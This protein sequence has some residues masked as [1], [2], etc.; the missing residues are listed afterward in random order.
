MNPAAL[1]ELLIREGYHE[2][3]FFAGA[4]Q[5][6]LHELSE[7]GDT[8]LEIDL[9][10]PLEK[11][12]LAFVARSLAVLEA[13]VK[14]ALL[15][16]FLEPEELSHFRSLDSLLAE[17]RDVPLRV[18]ALAIGSLKV[19]VEGEANEV[20][21]FFGKQTQPRRWKKKFIAMLSAFVGGGVVA[22][23]LFGL[24]QPP[25]N[26]PE[27]SAVTEPIEQACGYL[28]AGTV[29]TIKAGVVEAEIPCQ[30]APGYRR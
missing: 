30:D 8:R 29:L 15:F 19:T 23:S 17:F 10:I 3:S 26:I 27:P 6:F 16:T 24:P 7:G 28:P 1:Q 20:A 21:N 5:E 14:L 22:L 9:A 18:T 11:P 12:T 13:H 25:I 4:T 2:D